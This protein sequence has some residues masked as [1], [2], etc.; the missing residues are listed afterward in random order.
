MADNDITNIPA[1]CHGLPQ[2]ALAFE[3]Y[4]RFM[5]AHGH[6]YRPPV[7]E[8]CLSR[9]RAVTLIGTAPD[10]RQFGVGYKWTERDEVA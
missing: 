2:R 10:G 4:R 5:K 8:A 1:F 6:E 3:T 9:D 7:E